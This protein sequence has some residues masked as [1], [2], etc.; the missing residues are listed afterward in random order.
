MRRAALIGIIALALAACSQSTATTSSSTTT[1]TTTTTTTAPSTTSSTVPDP[2]PVTVGLAAG[3]VTLESRPT[4]IVSLS[5]S[6]TEMLFAIGAGDQVVAVDEYSYYPDEA[7]V[8][9][10]SGFAPNLEAIAAYDPDLVVVSNDADGIVGAL[11]AIEIPVA[12]LP[13][14]VVLDDT[15]T[16]IEQ[17]GAL[18]GHLETAVQLSASLQAEVDEIVRT[19]P[20]LTEA[21]TYYHELDPSLYA[22]TSSTFI[23]QV[24][25][26]LGLENIADPADEDGFGYPQLSAEYVIEA[27]PDFIFLADAQCCGESPETVA[28][29]PGWGTLSA[30][31]GGRVIEVDADL[32]SRWGPRIV[33]YLRYVAESVTEMLVASE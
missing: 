27:D 2:F 18:T 7:P 22:V 25:S 17:L 32:A 1:S 21:A 8:T 26:L 31:T 11:G 20:E 24:Y 12:V 29:R 23:G 9:D 15:F 33:D 4:R 3:E 5:P 6:A 13:A 28:A 16:Q 19:F 14:A 10:L 30:V